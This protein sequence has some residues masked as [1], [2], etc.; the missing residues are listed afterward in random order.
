[1]DGIEVALSLMR[2]EISCK[3]PPG[4]QVPCP[5]GRMQVLVVFRIFGRD[6]DITSGHACF[7]VLGRN[8]AKAVQQWSEQ[9]FEGLD[10]GDARFSRGMGILVE[11]LAANPAV[12]ILAGMRS[13]NEASQGSPARA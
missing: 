11:R 12:H 2:T 8:G 6:A 7:H 13:T 3:R 10:L 4:A 5:V 9:E 1:M